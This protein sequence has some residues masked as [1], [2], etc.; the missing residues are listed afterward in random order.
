MKL[1]KIIALNLKNEFEKKIN[2]NCTVIENAVE[3][4][5]Y[6]KAAVLY[7]KD[8]KIYTEIKTIKGK[9]IMDQFVTNL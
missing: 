1:E 6:Q 9:K 2:Y 7:K 4:I 8:E 3:P 5:H